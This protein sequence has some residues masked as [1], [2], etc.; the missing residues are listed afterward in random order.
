MEFKNRKF[1][2]FGDVWS[3]KYVDH[4]PLLGGQTDDGFNGGVISPLK[5]TIY[6]STK[7]PDGK[8]ISEETVKNN[9]RHELAHLIFL[10]GQY[11]NCYEDEPLVEWVAKS[12]GVLL[13]SHI[14]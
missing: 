7:W 8:P 2:F 5:R 13:N 4:A 10:S 3:I 1:N 6:I 12:L 9:L 11:L 14:I